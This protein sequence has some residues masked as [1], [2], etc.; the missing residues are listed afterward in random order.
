MVGSRAAST[1]ER[2]ISA[3]KRAARRLRF[4]LDDESV[5]AERATFNYLLKMIPD[6]GYE[7]HRYANYL[8]RAI[9]RRVE[10]TAA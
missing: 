6:D 8:A 4:R 1:L 2:A 9:P 5:K 7:A 3:H 10:R